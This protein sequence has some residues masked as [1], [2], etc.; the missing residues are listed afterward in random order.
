MKV[1]ETFGLSKTYVQNVLDVEYGRVR[2]R[3]R[4]RRIDALKD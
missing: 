4:N 3:L 2:V 1:V